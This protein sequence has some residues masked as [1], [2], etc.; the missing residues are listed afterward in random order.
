M[1]IIDPSAK[2]SASV[3]ALE[4]TV[5]GKISE[6]VFSRLADQFP[7]LWRRLA[8]QLGERLRQ[9]NDLITQRNPRPV[10]FIGSSKESLSIVRAIQSELQHDDF[11]VRPWTSGGIF[12]ASR[13]PIDDLERQVRT[14]D[15]AVF[16][17]GPDNVVVSRE[18]ISDA[19]MIGIIFPAGPT[20]EG[21][22]LLSTSL[23][24][25]DAKVRAE[26]MDIAATHGQGF[27]EDLS[28]LASATNKVI[29]GGW[30]SPLGTFN[31]SPVFGS[32]RSGV[33]IVDLDGVTTIVKK[34]GENS[35]EVLG[36]F[37]Q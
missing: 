13:F 4:R 32:L 35:F 5:L 18:K 1:A 24:G 21:G 26:A 30:V 11:V 14:A 2:R 36:P 19:P 33:G 16:V 7:E 28:A 3:F 20:F 8:V 12:G 22:G 15:F 31:G 23:S 37:R 25:T 27:S 6:P 29:P 17:L 9:R 10:I 34:V